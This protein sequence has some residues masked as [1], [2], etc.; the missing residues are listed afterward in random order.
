MKR[1]GIIM[2]LL[3]LT[4]LLYGQSLSV[5]VTATDN[6]DCMGRNCFY[7][8]P[9]ILINEVMLSPTSNDGSIAGGG[10]TRCGEWI[11]LYNPHKCDS[12]DISCYFLGNNAPDG[13]NFGGGFV[14]P[15]GTIVPPQG[16]ALVR[17]IHTA[18]PA[19]SLLVQNGGNVVD[20]VVDS[21]YCVGGGTR[22]WFPNAGGWFAFYNA[23]G[24]PQ[25]A[26]SWCSQTNSCMSCNP[27]TPAEGDCG[28]SGLLPSYNDIPA[29]HK[30]YITSLNPQ[31]GNNQGLSFRRIPDG[32]IWQPDPALPTYGTCNA[33]CVPPADPSCNAIAVAT[34]L[35]GTP[36]YSYQW[37]DNSSQTTDTAFAL[38]AGTYTVTVT[39][40]NGDTASAEVTVT[41][42][43]PFVS[44]ASSTFCL[45][46][47][48][49]VLTG[50]PSGG[51]Y[52][53][54]TFSH[55]L[56][57]FQDSAAVYQLTYT[58]TDTN[59]CQATADF[60]VTVN[61]T[62]D[63]LFHDTICQRE[64]YD[65]HGFHLTGTQTSTS[66]I[67]QID[68]TYLSVNQCDSTVSLA[69][70]IL[71][72]EIIHIDTSICEGEDFSA[73]GVLASADTL[74]VGTHL[75]TSIFTNSYGCD[76]TVNL[77]LTVYPVYD[78]TVNEML[79]QGDVY[80]Q[81]GFFFNT[82]TMALGAYEWVHS[83]HTS[84]GCDSVFTLNF[85]ILRRDEINLY[86]T[87]CQYGTYQQYH[88]SLSDEATS[89]TGEFT[90]EQQLQNEYGCDSIVRLHLTITPQPQA[91][92]L[93]NPERILFSENEEIQFLNITDLSS[94]GFGE[95]FSWHWDY[96]DG[97]TETSEEMNASHRYDTW[98]DFL[99][100]LTVIT[101]HDC[102]ST[103]SHPVFVEADL[104][105]PNVMTPNGDHVNDVFA[106][107][108]LN[109][110]LPNTLTIYNRWGKKV[111]E[112]EN[113]KTYIRD[114]IIYNEESAFTGD[115]LSDGVYYYVFRYVGH[116]H[117]VDYHSTLTLIR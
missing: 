82:D 36:P 74:T 115:N 12:A 75:Y 94:Y 107:K 24:V 83:T 26:I 114:G 28:Y 38:C 84:H 100:T 4:D 37:N 21:R 98:G 46:D 72:S 65:L 41:D 7:N 6:T 113:Y 61:P 78:L 80:Q 104:E 106:I 91:D 92:F 112:R 50:L 47:S 102:E 63:T 73:H 20:I 79:C 52:G 29:D 109:P 103:V 99:V 76:S 55:N 110:D 53:G 116:V 3:V 67:L 25:D 105:F 22:L 70:V 85:N 8:G 51:T 34:A 15:P 31:M 56:F 42:F 48:S 57:L 18:A 69:L 86:D 64:P 45:S 96:G 1:I 19:D 88:F 58:I 39:D 49:A 13:S 87:L 14:I 17:G 54:G 111:F 81:H 5:S 108:N 117:A 95:N 62:Y 33:D 32:G 60:T 68:T 43:L 27:C 23:A 2:F 89:E 9:T 59:G 35:G 101:D 16:F 97:A 30:N 40:N 10:D 44:H 90:H 93:S 77:N 66:G 71:P 11:E